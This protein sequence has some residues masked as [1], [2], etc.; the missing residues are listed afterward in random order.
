MAE[1]ASSRYPRSS[2][3]GG[4]SISPRPRAR[5]RNSP[6]PS[7]RITASRG[8]SSARRAKFERELLAPSRPPMM[9]NLLIFPA[10]ISPITVSRGST[11]LREESPG[12][13][14]GEESRPPSP[15]L[16]AAGRGRL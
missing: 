16:A 4:P 7:V 15:D 2:G 3:R 10:L 13:R 9:M 8:A 11:I 6:R 12:A 1:R 14:S 5:S